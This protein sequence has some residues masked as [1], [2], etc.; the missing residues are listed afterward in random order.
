[1]TTLPENIEQ[2]LMRLTE[3][4]KT[5]LEIVRALSDGIRNADEQ[6]LR[7]V[8]NV[9]FQHN[10]RR[11][12]IFGELQELAAQLCVLPSRNVMTAINARPTQ[13]MATAI[14][15]TANSNG[16]DWR[17]AA[18]KIDEELNDLLHADT[19]RH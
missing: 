16:G 6:M 4:S 10:V 1:M 8:R 11:E 19:S 9:A 14:E 15:G 7:E 5:E 17:K 2:M 12:A 18:Q 13:R 3:N